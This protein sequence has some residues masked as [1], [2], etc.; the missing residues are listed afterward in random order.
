MP[1]YEFQCERGHVTEQI[2]SLSEFTERIVCPECTRTKRGRKVSLRM[3][4]LKM[5]QT[6]PPKFVKGSGG[7]YAPTS[8]ESYKN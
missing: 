8:T 3:A 5:S 6:A 2:R 4:T 7:F 1:L